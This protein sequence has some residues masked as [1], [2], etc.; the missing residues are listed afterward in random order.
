MNTFDTQIWH[1]TEFR[2][3]AYQSEKGKYTRN[4]VRFITRFRKDFSAGGI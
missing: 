3:V 2:L 4:L 1:Q